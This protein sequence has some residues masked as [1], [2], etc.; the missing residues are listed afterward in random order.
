[1]QT[2]RRTLQYKVAKFLSGNGNLETKLRAAIAKL[3]TVQQREEPLTAENSSFRVLSGVMSRHG[4][5]CGRMLLYTPGQ[6]QSMLES[7]DA[8]KDY[9]VSTTAPPKGSGKAKREFVESML[10]FGVKDNHV[11]VLAS[12]SLSTKS[13][14]THINWLLDKAG[15]IKAGEEALLLADQPTQAARDAIK[16]KS[17]KSLTIGSNLSFGIQPSPSGPREQSLTESLAPTGPAA[18]ALSAYLGDWFGG[19]KLKDALKQANIRVKLTVSYVSHNKDSA[20]FEVM[21]ELAVAGRHF[22]E[23][24]AVIHLHGG[25]RIKGHDLRVSQ[26]LDVQISQD[27]LVVE[28]DLWAALGGWLRSAISEGKVLAA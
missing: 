20:G 3:N 27:G 11:M 19:Q 15:Q 1:M 25:G 10:F 13:L 2:R 14:E 16:G 26:S 24:D 8:S 6:R 7:D 18:E 9:V 23:E 4:I 28:A 17:I 12:T 22:D 21:E 5:E